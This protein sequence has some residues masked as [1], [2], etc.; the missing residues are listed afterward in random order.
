LRRVIVLTSLLALLALSVLVTSSSA[1]RGDWF[2]SPGLCK[3]RLHQYGVQINDGRTFHVSN[4]FCVG[5]GGFQHCEWTSSAHVKRLYNQFHIVVRSYDGSVRRAEF[6][7]T[8]KASYDLEQIRLIAQFVSAPRFT[9]YVAPI[10]SAWAR[11]EQ[12][13]GCSEG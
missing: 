3:S 6:F 7:P 2:W 10:T 1:R 13:K 4:S 5:V 9:S 8:G 12:A 11:S